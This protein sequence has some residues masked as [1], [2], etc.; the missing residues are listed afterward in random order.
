MSQASGTAFRYSGLANLHCFS[1]NCLRADNRSAP[2]S[3]R[4][5]VT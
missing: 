4:G 1:A 3:G 5:L 2:A